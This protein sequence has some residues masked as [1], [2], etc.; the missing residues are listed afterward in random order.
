MQPEEAFLQVLQQYGVPD[1]Q[2]NSLWTELA[3]AYNSP[4]RHYH[5]LHH[6]QDMLSHLQQATHLLHN[7]NSLVL[8]LC[9]HD[10]VYNTLKKDNEEQSALVAVKRLTAAALPETVIAQC[11]EAILATKKHQRHTHEDINLF[12]DADLAILGSPPATYQQYVQA[13]R[14][15]YAIYPDLLY[16]PGRRKVLQHFIAADTIFKT[17]FFRQQYEEQARKNIAMELEL[18]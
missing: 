12:T 11:R 10:M 13:I 1:T 5:N 14:K 15:E 7:A 3:D 6:L 18:L 4:K 8:A 17:A 16:N 2:I 9:Y